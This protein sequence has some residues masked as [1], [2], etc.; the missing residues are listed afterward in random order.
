MGKLLL[1]VAQFH[2]CASKPRAARSGQMCAKLWRCLQVDTDSTDLKKQ[3]FPAIGAEERG[4]PWICDSR[5]VIS[6]VLR[7]ANQEIANHQFS[8]FLIRSW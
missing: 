6:P 8:S 5:I 7:I 3:N 1:A 2:S 4:P